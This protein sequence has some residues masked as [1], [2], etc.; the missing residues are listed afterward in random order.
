MSN[1]LSTEQA[2]LR[3]SEAGANVL[4][5]KKTAGFL[6][7]FA[8]QF[9]SP[10][11]YVLLFAALLSLGLGQTINA[12]FIAIVLLINAL[13]GTVQEYSAERAAAGL[14]NMVPA[15]TTVIRDGKPSRIVTSLVVPGDIVL[16]ASGD[17]VPADLHLISTYNLHVDES[18]LT[19]ESIES[20]KNATQIS[21][22]N[23]PLADRIDTCFAGTVILRGRGEGE[24]I[25]TGINTEIGKIAG[26]VSSGDE[27]KPPLLVRTERF[28]RIITYGILILIAIIFLI[29]VLRG[30]D[31][32]TVF[33]VGIALAVSAIPEGLPAAITIAL[34][35]GMQRMARKGVIIRRL[36]AVESLGSCTYIASD[37]TGTLTVNDMTIQ[38]ILL[39]NG[40]QYHVSG[41]GM[42]LHGA[43]SPENATRDGK[44]LA[45]LFET[46]ALANEA[47]L[48]NKEGQ[49]TGYG[50][51]VDVAFLI[52]AGKSGIALTS[53]RQKYPELTRIPYESENAYC[54]SVNQYPDRIELLAKG[55]VECLLTM[56]NSFVGINGSQQR[57]IEQAETLARQGFRVLGLAHRQLQ[58]LP[59]D[60]QKYLHDLEFIGMVG[61]I[62]PLRPD[63]IDSINQCREARIDVAMITGDHP[64]TALALSTQL[65]IATP[66]MQAV[67][68]SDLSKASAAGRDCFSSLV[69]GSRVFAR[70]EPH[71]KKQIVEQ[72]IDDGEFV[73]VTGDGVNDA[74]AL[75]Y[76]HVGIAM[77]LRGA[78]VARESADIILTDDRF[79]SIVEGIKQGRIVYN[80]IRKVIFLLIS[81]GAAEIILVILSLV[82]GMPLPLLPLQLL[83][84]NLVTNGIQDVALAFEPEEGD[85]LKRP[86][87]APNEPIFNRLMIERVL[88][89]ALVMGLLAFSIFSLQLSGGASLET[90]RNVTLLLMVLFENV[91]VLNSRSE[92]RSIFRQN[93]FGNPFLI[94]GMLGAQAVHIGAMYTPFLKDILE[95]QPV[96]FTLWTQLLSVSLFLIVMD[97]LHK[98]W[99]ARQTR[100]YGVQF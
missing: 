76:S 81:T 98:L 72:L 21:L 36:L 14:K 4:P 45:F 49:W 94:F 7:V 79:S 34:A 5:E 44:H 80:N 15:Q 17:K 56:C 18:M 89:N 82:S 6:I 65:G 39:P 50:D 12:I 69:H 90:A 25:A 78:D 75:S 1:G 100:P 28:S 71:Q 29:T 23:T 52:L 42:D 84:L 16:L 57:I 86:P 62:D 11:V 77:G 70:V 66:S 68:G 20:H 74:P 46:G 54:A 53:L 93:F 31:L 64:Q 47:K 8:R 48:E 27:V 30:D 32:A 10:F 51:R 3:L 96:T 40:Q 33:L 88:L 22:G 92:V 91:H 97:E 37:K 58:A 26:E 38:R 2:A 13:I 59:A 61:M 99:H 43:I 95:I 73:A 9:K 60:P 87:R 67:N 35:I 41:E 63:A 55:S 83:W 85:E 24:V 19:G